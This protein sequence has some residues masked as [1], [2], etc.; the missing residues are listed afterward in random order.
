MGAFDSQGRCPW[1]SQVCVQHIL[2]SDRVIFRTILVPHGATGEGTAKYMLHYRLY[3]T[4]ADE[5]MNGIIAKVAN[6]CHPR[7]FAISVFRKV[8]L[9]AVAKCDCL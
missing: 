8:R 1:K 9:H 3:H 7:T 6:T 2:R 4:Y 5:A